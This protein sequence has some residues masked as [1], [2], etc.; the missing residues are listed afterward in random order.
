MSLCGAHET[1]MAIK[2]LIFSLE[3]FNSYISREI[4]K[5]GNYAST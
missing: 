3:I 2:Q 5:E 4:Y 1:L